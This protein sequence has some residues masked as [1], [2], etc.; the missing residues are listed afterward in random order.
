M[1]SESTDKPM[2]FPWS[3][4]ATDKYRTVEEWRKIIPEMPVFKYAK[5]GVLD[6][7]MR[8]PLF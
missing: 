8:Y 2:F 3:A 4:F 7:L 1:L 6:K 5:L